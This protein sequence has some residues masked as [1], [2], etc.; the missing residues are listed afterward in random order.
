MSKTQLVDETGQNK[1]HT[2]IVVQSWTVA[3]NCADVFQTPTP[4]MKCQVQL[5]YFADFKI[6]SAQEI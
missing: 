1:K 4:E 2:I 6:N 5:Q 3:D